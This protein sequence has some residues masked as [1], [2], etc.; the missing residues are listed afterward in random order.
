MLIVC[1]GVDTQHYNPITL[2][3]GHLYPCF[4]SNCPP[5]SGPFAKGPA[6]KILKKNSHHFTLTHILSPGLTQPR[7]GGSHRFR[8]TG[9]GSWSEWLIWS[10]G[11]EWNPEEQL[12]VPGPRE[13]CNGC[14]DSNRT[15]ANRTASYYIRF[16]YVETVPSVPQINYPRH[17]FLKI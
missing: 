8:R 6:G 16:N 1:T 10:S 17:V 15:T 2:Y 7:P 3:L 4:Q 12:A 13:K 9:P 5:E 11:P 14:S